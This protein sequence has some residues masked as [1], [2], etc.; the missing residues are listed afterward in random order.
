MKLFELQRA[1]AEKQKE[2]RSVV[3]KAIAEGRA[4]TPDESRAVDG[5]RAE[6]LEL[7]RKITT[8]ELRDQFDAMTPDE[9]RSGGR[10]GPELP[11]L[12]GGKHQY[13]LLRALNMNLMVRE[14]KAKYSGLEYEVH[15]ELEKHAER[16]A[17]GIRIPLSLRSG[18]LA[19]R[20]REQRDLTTATASGSIANI[21]GMDL[22]GI[23][24]NL[25]VMESMGAKV[26]EGLSGGS[27]SLP[28]QTAT[29]TAYHVAEGAPPSASNLALTQ[30]T[31]TPRTIGAVTNLSRKALI[32]SSLDLEALA[33]QDIMA[34][35]AREFDRVGLNG[36]GQSSVPLG[37]MQDPNVPTVVINT[38]GGDPTWNT[39][40]DLESSVAS[41]NADFGSLGYV[42]STKGRGKLKKTPKL[43]STFPV[44]LW[45]KGENPGEG[46]VN[47]YRA[48]AT[49]QIPDNLTKGSGTALTALLFGNFASATYGLWS[50]VDVL[51][52]PY[53][54]S[55][56]GAVKVTAFQD[57][58][59]QFRYETAFAKCVDMN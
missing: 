57:Y 18:S 39:L 22:I 59:M 35:I 9:Q 43:G 37:V 50:G 26:L 21:L 55:S 1:L 52:D 5:A 28:K 13:S 56:T 41:Y 45:D 32:Q 33:R 17:D 58:D 30:V 19:A 40:V 54:G 31:W 20:A 4:L 46:E 44:F 10:L 23:L 49:N 48:M 24:R 7:Q 51:V 34:S 14:G 8:F 36:S 27:F 29:A 11:E 2:G 6:I 47:S 53:T 25:M 12:D 3:E 42:C 16:K 38:N 15:C